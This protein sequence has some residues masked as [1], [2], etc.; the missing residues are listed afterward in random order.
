MKE[1]I[2]KIEFLSFYDR[3]GI[4]KR[5]EEMAKKGWLIDEITPF[6]WIYKK[7]EPQ[8]LKFDITFYDKASEFDAK[9]SDE[10]ER[11]YDLCQHN[12][13]NFVFSSSKMQIFSNENIKATAINT[14]PMLDIENIHQSAKKSYIP[15]QTILLIISLVF[16]LLFLIN[17]N[18]EIISYLSSPTTIP[19]GILAILM[20]LF[21]FEELASYFIWYDKALK[22]AENEEFLETSSHSIFQKI[23]MY[24]AIV[25]FIITYIFVILS[26]DGMKILSYTLAPLFIL[27]YF[28]EMRAKKHFKTKSLSKGRNQLFTL[29]SGY[30]LA[31]VLMLIMFVTSY[32]LLENGIITINMPEDYPLYIKE[33]KQIKRVEYIAERNYSKSVF[34]EQLKLNEHSNENKDN[35]SLRY[36]I[37]TINIPSMYNFCEKELRKRIEIIFKSKALK[38]NSTIFNAEKV[39]SIKNGENEIY[40]LCYADKL[41]ELETNFALNDK[42]KKIIGQKFKNFK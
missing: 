11:L 16:S 17:I 27:V 31:L 38:E 41:I 39:Y 4:I 9:P 34:F 7:I 2:R 26:G 3:T 19:A 29:L 24:T 37:T 13:W 33:L 8:N 15:L 40:L 23:F 35:P 30:G 42:D 28:V 10:Q 22:I 5:L 21:L 1:R 14:E 18:T 32:L 20:S 36:T 6:T 25:I 12:G